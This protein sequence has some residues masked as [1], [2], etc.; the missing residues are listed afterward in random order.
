MTDWFVCLSF[1]SCLRLLALLVCDCVSGFWNLY[2][3][4]VF[5]A[6]QIIVLNFNAHVYSNVFNV[7][8]YPAQFFTIF[9]EKVLFTHIWHRIRT[10][11]THTHKRKPIERIV[12][13]HIERYKYIRVPATNN[14]NVQTLLRRCVRQWNEMLNEMLNEF[15][16]IVIQ[17][18][19]RI[20]NQKT[21][22]SFL[23]NNFSLAVCRNKQIYHYFWIFLILILIRKWSESSDRCFEWFKYN[24]S[25]GCRT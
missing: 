11:H 2:S 24:I 13:S 17:N 20:N 15:L 14:Q 6:Y 18:E 5:N 9:G 1:C 21:R 7:Q 16:F 10:Q 23:M 22:E 19:V 4:A 12:L 8:C 3:N 25:M